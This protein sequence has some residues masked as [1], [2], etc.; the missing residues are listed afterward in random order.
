MITNPAGA[1]PLGDGPISIHFLPLP[2]LSGMQ[3]LMPGSH[4]HKSGWCLTAWRQP[5]I[6]TLSSVTNTF[7][8]AKAHAR[9]P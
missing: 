9:I 6:N 8:H 3:R 5:N 2:T 4:D 7:W 1:L